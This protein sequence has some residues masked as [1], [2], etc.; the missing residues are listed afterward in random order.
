MGKDAAGR[1]YDETVIVDTTGTPVPGLAAPGLSASA[2]VTRPADT[3][4]YLA[5]DVLGPAAGTSAL[6]FN[7]GAR[8]G[9]SIMITSVSLERDVAAL[10]SGEAGYNLYLYSVTP[11]SALADNAPFDIP[12]GDRAS[13]L[14]KIPIGTPVDEGSTLYVESYAI[15]KPVKLAGTHLFAYLVSVGAYTPASATVLKVTLN[16]VQL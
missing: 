13:F 16:A 8:S 14:G 9:S 12:A 10:I 7:L 15:N 6:D 11:P 3:N 2:T 1:Y 5:N 4:A